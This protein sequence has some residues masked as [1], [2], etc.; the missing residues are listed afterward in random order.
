MSLVESSCRMG[1][2]QGRCD[3]LVMELGKVKK[4]YE[5]VKKVGLKT[6]LFEAELGKVKKE[7]AER[8]GTYV[9][10]PIFPPIF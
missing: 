9:L 2:P 8:E 4:E 1:E 3:F 6:D 10:S 7:I 5:E